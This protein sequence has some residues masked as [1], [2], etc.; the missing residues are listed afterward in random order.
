[1]RDAVSLAAGR[2]QLEASGN[3]SLDTVEAIA[4][5]GVDIISVGGLTHSPRAVDVSL[6]VSGSCTK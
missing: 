4:H 2:V 1:M 5:T 6:K 3:V